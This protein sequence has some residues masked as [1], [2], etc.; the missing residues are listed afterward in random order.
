MRRPFRTRELF[1][2]GHLGRCPRLVWSCAVGAQDGSV[3]GR[4]RVRSLAIPG[5]VGGGTPYGVLCGFVG[6]R[7]YREWLAAR[8]GY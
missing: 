1:L 6:D 5:L 4:G 7:G 3:V 2:F 8:P